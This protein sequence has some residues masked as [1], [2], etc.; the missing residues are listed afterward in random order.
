MLIV[1]LAGIAASDSKELVALPLSEEGV[2]PPA[3]LDAWKLVINELKR[4]STRLGMS[5][6]LQKKR[7]DF[8]IGPAREQARDCGE[9]VECL[10]EIGAALGADVLV[11]G[12]LDATSV[13]LIAIDVKNSKRIG[14]GRS[15]KKLA[16][17]GMRRRAVAATRAL[18]DT[19][20]KPTGGPLASKAGDENAKGAPAP[21]P[22]EDLKDD[23]GYMV[24][25]GR[26]PAPVEASAPADGGIHLAKDQLANVAEVSVDGEPLLFQGDGSM[27][28]SGAPGSHSLIAVRNDG[29]RTTQEI[30][31]E[32][33]RTTEV[34][35][36]FAV[37]AVATT[38][39]PAASA[40]TG[41]SEDGDVFTRWWFWTSIGAAV[42]A[43]ATTAALLAG[44]TKGGPDI[45]GGTGT[46]RGRY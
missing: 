6:V 9:N 3:G 26:T 14:T 34:T 16:G 11:A 39:T 46:I 8:L 21:P 44:G 24:D 19:M 29:H 36:A 2:K 31:I 15:G 42:V 43:G 25:D 35:L 17:S 20:A 28:W 7:H 10:A 13:T 30:A 23:D 40:E 22:K 5:M 18:I 37:D 41:S 38:R 1:F 4:S 45:E 27:V 12:T 33:E 32:P